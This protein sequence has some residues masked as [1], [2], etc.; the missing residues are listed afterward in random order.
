MK[1]SLSRQIILFVGISLAMTST[2]IVWVSQAQGS[3][4]DY[5]WQ[6][7]WVTQ[8]TAPSENEQALRDELASEVQ[9]LL[10]VCCTGQA[11]P[12]HLGPYYVGA[13]NLNEN[14][15][16]LNPA[17]TVLVLS[18]VLE[19][20]APA[21]RD[22]VIAYLKF[23]MESSLYNP[24]AFE[25][26]PDV[27]SPLVAKD[28][29]RSFGPPLPDELAPAALSEYIG[30]GPENLYAAWA[31]AHY[32][33]Q[34]EAPG[35]SPTA[36]QIID[37][38][39]P[40]IEALYGQIP[41]RPRTYWE[42]MAAIGYARMARQL[43]RPYT[44]A[45]QRA[46]AGLNAGVDYAQFYRNMGQDEGCFGNNGDLGGHEGTWDY[47][48]F[49][50]VSPPV[51]HNT[52]ND[53]QSYAGDFLSNRPSMFSVEIGRFL[54]DNAQSAVENHLNRYMAPGGESYFPAWW[55]NKGTKPWAVRDDNT[56]PPG[57]GENAIMHPSFA[58]QL[59]MLRA[60]V[61][62][63][64]TGDSMRLFLDTPWTIG[65]MFHI[66][67]LMIL[68]RLYSTV[69][70]A[71][72]DPRP[73][74]PTPT[75][76]PTF[77]STSINTNTVTPSPPLTPLTTPIH[78]GT[79]TGTLSPTVSSTPTGTP[80]M[81]STATQTASP[82]LA[83]APTVEPSLQYCK[84]AYPLIISA[85]QT[86]TYT[87]TVVHSGVAVTGST[88]LTDTLPLELSYVPNSLTTTRGLAIYQ[89]NQVLWM[90]TMPQSDYIT[91]TYQMSVPTSEPMT[92]TNSAEFYTQHVDEMP[93]TASAPI[94]IN[95]LSL[96]LP[97][98]WKD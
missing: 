98:I 57:N 26:E 90:D 97:V 96:Y 44:Q 48:A 91:I 63:D 16:W 80:F 28:N 1:K 62:P 40:N 73:P 19:F 69:E 70:W 34:F 32:V 11:T 66:Q 41:A 74:T 47:C 14:F 93:V 39:W 7:A 52:R 75:P 9:K 60:M 31:F 56:A 67:K 18:E 46:L 25:I 10:D 42:V 83:P 36:W 20:L 15:Y 79:S 12:N 33:S 85:G 71:E 51:L 2:R 37:Q 17:E 92:V 78:T 55:E 29:F 13:G 94:F 59:F 21:Q 54:A 76:C 6:T 24:L 8:N 72:E 61:F 45:E 84:W 82:T 95:P 22:E 65:D 88:W 38:N 86:V 77:T 35:P 81:T 89:D 43:G 50:A 23:E 68:L 4:S 27:P 5:I 3:F 53:H 30:P 64:E 87:L 58:W 49:T